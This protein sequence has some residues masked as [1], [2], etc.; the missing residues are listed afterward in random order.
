M[1]SE[2][3]LAHPKVQSRNSC[4]Q[5]DLDLSEYSP[6]RKSVKSVFEEVYFKQN[7]GVRIFVSPHSSEISLPSIRVFFEIL[8]SEGVP[9]RSK[10][11]F[12]VETK[13]SVFGEGYFKQNCGEKIFVSSLSSEIELPS[14]PDFLAVKN[15]VSSD[16]DKT[17][18]TSRQL[19]LLC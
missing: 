15:P 19:S 12:E 11:S 6:D 4:A 9:N 1:S 8:S 3:N 16:T 10:K 18:L 17:P 14:K 7:C 2:G 13:K 5:I